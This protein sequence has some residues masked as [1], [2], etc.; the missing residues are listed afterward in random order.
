MLKNKTTTISLIILLIFFLITGFLYFNGIIKI[1]FQSKEKQIQDIISLSQ[2]Y[3]VSNS[4]ED[5]MSILNDGQKKFPDSREIVKMKIFNYYITDKIENANKECA[6]LEKMD[7]FTED[8]IFLLKYALFTK[9][10]PMKEKYVK[11]LESVYT[12]TKNVYYILGYAYLI[13][14]N[15]KKKNAMFEMGYNSSIYLDKYNANYFLYEN[16]FDKLYKLLRN[17]WD[18][19][20]FT[21]DMFFNLSLISTPE[22]SKYVEEKSKI[23]ESEF[24]KIVLSTLYYHSER[25]AEAILLVINMTSMENNIPY[26]LLLSDLYDKL[27]SKSKSQ[28]LRGE[29]VATNLNNPF[30]HYILAKDALINKNYA[31]AMSEGIKASNLNINYLNVYFDIFYTCYK[32]NNDIVNSRISLKEALF[33]NPY[34]AN[35]HNAFGILHFN[36][37]NYGESIECFKNA[38]NLDDTSVQYFINLSKAYNANGETSNTIN[39]LKEALK[40]EEA[41]STLSDLSYE[42]VK[43]YDFNNAKVIL[44]KLNKE[45]PLKQKY[46]YQLAVINCYLKKYSEALTL[47]EKISS[48]ISDSYY[49]KSNLISVKLFLHKIEKEEAINEFTVILKEKIPEDL[50]DSLMKNIESINSSNLNLTLVFFYNL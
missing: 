13:D 8:K 32:E 6:V 29:I 44:D 9:N 33:I 16:N 24:N 5:S 43:N 34:D 22:F 47:F 31:K 25:Y 7:L 46:K 1:N 36:N 11:E 10:I 38:I 48:P 17:E 21:V 3:M 2:E 30:I 37:D 15:I 23:Y 49:F 27:N 40:L 19:D 20:G 28:K 12:K 35:I 39:T 18:D 14:G 41:E 26:K 42:Y 50:R 4:F 45:Y